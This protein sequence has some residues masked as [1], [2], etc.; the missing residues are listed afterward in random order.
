MSEPSEPSV[1]LISMP[2]GALERPSLGLGLLQAAAAR[3][4]FQ[5]RTVYLGFELADRIGVETY[6]WVHNLPYAAFIG[7]WLFTEA[8]YGSRPEADR[9]FLNDVLGAYW[10]LSQGDRRRLAAVKIACTSFVEEIASSL[11]W[12]QYDVIGWTSTFHQNIASLALAERVKRAAPNTTISFGGANWEGAMGRALLGEFGFVDVCFSGEADA[13]FPAMLGA[14]R[15]G[16]SLRD[17]PG[18]AYRGDTGEVESTGACVA[19]TDL[20]RLPVPDFAPY[21]DALANCRDAEEIES[22]LLLETARGCW[23]GERSHCTFCG[24]NGASMAFRSKNPERVLAE[25]KVLAREYGIPMFVVVDNILDMRYFRS[26]LVELAESDESFSFFWEVKANLSRSQVRLLSRAGVDHIQPGIESMSDRVLDLM[27]KGTTRFR[28]VALL[29]WCMEYGVTPEWNLL[30]GFPGEQVEDYRD[31]A[32][33]F[34]K[35]RHLAPP[36]GQGSVRLDRFSPYHDD[37]AAYGMAN[38]RPVQPLRF[39]YPD[40]D[41]R[42]DEISY[43]F[44]FDYADGHDPDTCAAPALAAMDAWKKSHGSSGLWVIETRPGEI[45]IIDERSEPRRTATVDGWKASI[46]LACDRARTREELEQMEAMEVVT[47]E[48]LDRYLD[49][50]L[51]TGLMITD[52]LSYL[53]LAVH[54]PP[55]EETAELVR[56]IPLAAV[57]PR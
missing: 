3:D 53:S 56:R 30:Y 54:Q 10:H 35:I 33:L 27:R 6:R 18:L 9:Q 5:C 23:W 38:V 12:A 46:Y 14:L 42:L 43:Y 52:G 44:D 15:Y 51:A 31:M 55:R 22:L 17:I 57:E 36:S 7:E 29:K 49:R 26:L 39:L 2:F 13:S 34:L 25:I 48:A 4:G 8:L 28:N 45:M 21:F 50:C 11:D 1:L 19:V 16:G 47:N 24:L 32:N 20:D 41:Q 40:A 37:P